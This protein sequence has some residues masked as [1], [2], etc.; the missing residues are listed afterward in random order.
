[1]R[2]GQ[3]HHNTQIDVLL[4]HKKEMSKKIQVHPSCMC[5]ELMTWQKAQ[6]QA[7]AS[8]KAH[9]TPL[10][11]TP[12]YF[13]IVNLDHYQVNN[14]MFNTEPFYSHPGGY[15]MIMTVY[16]N[17]IGESRDKYVSVYVG[18]LRGEFDD[19][20]QWPFS[21]SVTVEAYNRTLKQW[22]N[23]KEIVLNPH[24][25]DLRV[26]SNRVNILVDGK[27]GYQD[28]LPLDDFEND[29]VKSFNAARFRVLHVKVY[30]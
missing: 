12:Y 19:D 11:L 3:L 20:L 26:V 2:G 14:Y 27:K 5:G 30:S 18:I 15:K 8:L 1:M 29:Y 24:E 4:K 21:G 13:L 7:I 28:F 17:G 22:S 6:D 9:T 23:R 10:T 25:C 16:P